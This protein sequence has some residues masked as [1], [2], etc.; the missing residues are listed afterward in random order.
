MAKGGSR[1]VPAALR[2]GL[3]SL[4]QP[5]VAFGL[6]LVGLVWLGALALIVQEQRALRLQVA[7]DAENYALIVEQSV[8]DT[9]NALDRTLK[10]VRWAER[11]DDFRPDWQ[12]ILAEDY[13]VDDET[14]QIAVTDAKGIGVASSADLHS[15]RPID[16]SDRAHFRAQ[17]ASSQDALFIGGVVVGRISGKLSVQFSRKRVD[18]AGRFLGIVVISLAA[19]HFDRHFAKLDLGAGGG[20]ALVGDDGAVR[21]GSGA[22]RRSV[23]VNFSDF[24]PAAEDSEAGDRDSAFLA[25]RPVEGYPLKV[26][27]RL[28]GI[29]A[30]PNWRLRRL[31]YL[32]C[33]A[34][35]SVVALLATIGV[36]LR[37]HRYERRILHL[38]RHDSLTGLPNRRNLLARLDGL[39]AL[40]AEQRDF[41]LHIL[42]LDRF[43]GVNDTYGHAAGDELLKAV[44][45]RL[46][47]LVGAQDI[48]ARLG[49]DEFAVIQ[50]V[51]D[52][53]A[54]AP[55]LAA[56][57]CEA[58]AQPFQGAR[59]ALS[60]GATIG[61]ACGRRDGGQPGELMKAA[62]LALYATKTRR[63]GAAGVY[64]PAMMEAAKARL[65]LETGLRS[66]LRNGEFQIV[67]QPIK[68][69]ATEATLG[70]EA[71]LRWRRADGSWVSP[72]EFIPVAEEL[73]LIVEIGKWVLEQACAAILA[74]PDHLT[75]AVN[76]S[77]AQ[78][79]ASNFAQ[80]V[81]EALARSGLAPQR[82]HV[83]ITESMLMKDRVGVVEQLAQIRAMGVGVSID[84]FG[85]GYSCLS[86][87]EMYPIDTL[88]I[89]RQFVQKLGLRAEAG[90]TIR[91]IVDLAASFDMKI[92]AEGVE[93]PEQLR[94]L[95]ELGCGEAQGY[96]LGRPGP[97]PAPAPRPAAASAPA[98]A[99]APAPWRVAAA[100][101]G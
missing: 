99:P 6:A 72:A 25:A 17:A 70:Y 16:V 18:A 8:K 14:V 35:A 74:C 58:L 12:K 48:A 94:A 82:L 2:V 77:P 71:L 31:V 36:A 51:A 95:R 20:L 97:L 41:A 11:H 55:A 28:P 40:P 60:I 4:R 93:T 3:Q 47:A 68:S 100:A 9:I 34:A 69:V 83:E 44:A 19:D 33:A 66:A 87:L 81:R 50:R 32:V 64:D 98:A 43:K 39:C 59:A 24:D 85:T 57:I 46:T 63:R 61:I 78:Y 53:D 92:I 79:A 37:R 23:G 86:Y 89:D 42:D 5:V 26:M 54:E 38:S 73:G 30:D 80:T 15:P 7:R 1:R 88:K 29:E 49:G 10:Y 62:D 21:A 101:A 22:Y 90:A 91:A 13:T 56:R 75:V 67:Y 65:G 52:F 27:V 76:S 45:D 84:D 96:L